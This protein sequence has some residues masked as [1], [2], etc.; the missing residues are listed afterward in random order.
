MGIHDGGLFIPGAEQDGFLAY[1]IK[2]VKGQKW[3]SRDEYIQMIRAGGGG[4]F[5]S[6]VEERADWRNW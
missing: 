3:N 1:P 5:L 4:I 2:S 6:H